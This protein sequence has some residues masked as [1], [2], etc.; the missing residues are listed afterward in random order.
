MYFLSSH[1]RDSLVPLRPPL[2]LSFS[3][4]HERIYIYQAVCYSARLTII[5]VQILF[6]LFRLLSLQ[7]VQLLIKKGQRSIKNYEAVYVY[8]EF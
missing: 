3:G 4:C 5:I 2:I 6:P 7:I 8:R 1:C